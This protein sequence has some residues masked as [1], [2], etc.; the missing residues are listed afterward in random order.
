MDMD[1][2]RESEMNLSSKE[3][4]RVL[5][6]YEFRL[7]RKVTDAARNICSTM[8]EDTLSIRTAQHC[9]NRFKSGNFELNDSRHSGRPLEVA[10]DV[11]KQLIEE[12]PR[13]TSCYLAAQ[14]G[15]SHT[16]EE[17][18]LSELDK[19]SKYGVWIPHE[20]SLHQLQLRAD[21]CMALMT[22]HRNYQWL[23]SRITGDE[24]W[25]LYVNHTRKRQW[26]GTGQIGMATPQ[27]DLHPRKTML[28]VWWSVR[29]ISHWEVIPNGC[30]TAADL[31]C[32]QLDCVAA[33]LQGKQDRVY[34]LHDNARPHVAKSTREKLLKLG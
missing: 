7:G 12:D 28:G 17:T 21:T 34:F 25:M 14:L 30:T 1:V 10:V 31:Y 4:R 3:L 26:Q 6:L 23:H 22:S 16:T 8:G 33:K 24:K 5:L 2:D 11:L 27:N 20:L 19:T 13:L 32:Q 18:H 9:F 15:C 29:E